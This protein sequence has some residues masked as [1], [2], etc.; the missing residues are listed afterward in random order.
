MAP[1][2]IYLYGIR[3]L[4]KSENSL[5]WRPVP[6]PKRPDRPRQAADSEQTQFSW[7]IAKTA[8]AAVTIVVAGYVLA[9]T[10]EAIAEQTGLGAS[11]VGAVLV[12]MSTSLPEVSTVLSAVR[13]GNYTMAISDILGTN[14]FDIA[15]LFGVDAF[16]GEQAVLNRVGRF[17]A[18][19]AVIG[20]VVTALFTVG[21]IER[22][23]RTILRMGFDSAAVLVTYFAGL[24]ILFYLR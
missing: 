19:A 4:A 22:R 14:L 21:L 6:E 9:K 12:A 3:L 24:V 23:D 18:F 20:I 7:V 11:F 13:L 15:L 1:L 17:S 16:D 10:G 8:I 5:P 2:A